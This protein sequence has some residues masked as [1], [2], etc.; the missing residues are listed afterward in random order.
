MVPMRRTTEERMLVA[1]AL[2]ACVWIAAMVLWLAAAIVGAPRAFDGRTMTLTEAAAVAS[3]ADAYRLLEEGADPNAAAR[4]RAG[5]VR[6][7]AGS[8]TPLE[9]ATGAIR[10]GPVQMLV[11]HG[12]AIDDRTYPVL[13]CAASSRRNQDIL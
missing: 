2:P 6:N 5:L 12:A 13:W 4:L 3:H 7:S 9:A 8:M 1:V 10:T 11:E